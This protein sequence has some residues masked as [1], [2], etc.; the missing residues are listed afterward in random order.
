MSLFQKKYVSR[1]P[2]HPPRVALVL[3]A[4]GSKGIAH[5]GV[6]DVLKKADIPVDLVIGC[7]IGA[8]IGAFYADGH[9]PDYIFERALKIIPKGPDYKILGLPS[10][11][12]GLAGKGFFSTKGMY[13][14]LKKELR[15]K[16]FEELKVPL[17]VVATD[18][19]EGKLTIFNSGSLLKPLCASSAIPGFFQAVKIGNTQYVDGAIISELPVGTARQSGA[20]V[21]ISSDVKG[22][23]DIRHEGVIHNVGVR[24]YYIMRHHFDQKEEKADVIIRPDLSGV[25]NVIF[26]KKKIMAEVYERGRKSAEKQLPK[27]KALLNA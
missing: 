1:V 21:V 6:L 13:S 15:A 26:S 4:G 27:I 3:G 23:I 11:L 2:G 19:Q 12:N 8:L 16:T 20:Q 9:E 24:S 22:W 10:P 5:I 25:M 7:S 18:L 17:Q 14:I